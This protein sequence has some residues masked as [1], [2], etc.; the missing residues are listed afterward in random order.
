[1]ES[2]RNMSPVRMSS[3][4]LSLYK[5]CQSGHSFL[6]LSSYLAAVP[7]HS[8]TNILHFVFDLGWNVIR[9][10]KAVVSPARPTDFWTL[11]TTLSPQYKRRLPEYL[12]LPNLVFMHSLELIHPVGTTRVAG[13]W[14]DYPME[15]KIRVSWGSSFILQNTMIRW[16]LARFKGE[17]ISYISKVFPTNTYHLSPHFWGS[18]KQECS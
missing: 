15:G 5:S 11:P 7:P 3:C 14:L 8:S 16:N 18:Q 4:A 2:D 17:G 10:T 6:S 13:A 12:I 1:M 9:H